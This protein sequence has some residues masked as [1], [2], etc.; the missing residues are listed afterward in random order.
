MDKVNWFDPTTAKT[1]TRKTI[2]IAPKSGGKRFEFEVNNKGEISQIED[3][4]PLDWK[5]KKT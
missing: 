5:G 2:E 4:V 3:G 1:G